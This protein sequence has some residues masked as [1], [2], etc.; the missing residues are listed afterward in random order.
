MSVP[1][2]NLVGY[3][4]LDGD[5][6]DATG[7]GHTGADTTMSYS[8]TNA[9]INQ[10]GT[11][12][13]TTSKIL[14]PDSAGF[15]SP[16]TAVS[17]TGWFYITG[18]VTGTIIGKCPI[19][20]LNGTYIR[21]DVN[22][23]K[24]NATIDGD[25]TIAINGT[26]SL[27]TNTKYFAALTYDGATVSLWLGAGGTV[28]KDAADQ[29]TTIATTP[30]TGSVGI[31]VLGD[32]ASGQF[33]GAGTIDEVSWWTR[34]LSASEI[35]ELYNAGAGLAYPF[36]GGATTAANVSTLGLLHVG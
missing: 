16:T 12:N 31:G 32:F 18:T 28:A 24:L 6:S 3:W 26:T 17:L 21:L 35:S 4:K 1:T 29:S 10:A 33:I 15:D 30:G 7:N 13:G 5:S 11:F 22:G 9:V 36:T 8:T 23:A 25:S 34:G 27:S 14:I 2:T 20:G 19:A